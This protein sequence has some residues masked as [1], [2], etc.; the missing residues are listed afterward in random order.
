MGFE[1]LITKPHLRQTVGMILLFSILIA[2][3]VGGGVAPAPTPTIK[4][5][6]PTIGADSPANDITPGPIHGLTPLD[7]PDITTLTPT[8]TLTAT[9]SPELGWAIQTLDSQSNVDGFFSLAVDSQGNPHVAYL[10]EISQNHE[11]LLY[12]TRQGG[13]WLSRSI[14]VLNNADMQ[15][16][17]QRAGYMASLAIDPGDVPHVSYLVLDTRRVFVSSRIGSGW[18]PTLVEVLNTDRGAALTDM[19]TSL[20]I[21]ANGDMHLVTPDPD[22]GYLLKYYVNQTGAWEE[23]EITPSVWVNPAGVTIPLAV[24]GDVASVAYYDNGLYYLSLVEG[25][26]PQPVDL[27]ATVGL[28]PALAFDVQ[29][30]PH[31]VYYDAGNLQLKHACLREATWEIDVVQTNIKVGR[32]PGI[33]IAPDGGIHLSYYDKNNGDLLYAYQRPGGTEFDITVVDS[34]GT[35][36]TF[37]CIG[38][39]ADNRPMIIYFDDDHKNLKF[40]ELVVR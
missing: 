4:L 2:G 38:L 13:T 17:G 22:Q 34:P 6:L 8:S 33:A 31:I 5:V 40:A 3:C 23:V 7:P 25:Q 26:A 18:D 27:G 11:V 14:P 19:D 32:Y 10:N 20:G 16:M 37:S 15:T 30:S 21:G 39:N 9:P 28:M 12:N 24:Y 36:G 29:G 35:V 1:T